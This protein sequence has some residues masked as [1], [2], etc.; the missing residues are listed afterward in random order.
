MCSDNQYTNI[1]LTNTVELAEWLESHPDAEFVSI[2]TS[3]SFWSERRDDGMFYPYDM[4]EDRHSLP[5]AIRDHKNLKILVFNGFGMC[6]LTDV[7]ILT[8]A[9]KNNNVLKALCITI[10]PLETT[11]EDK[12]RKI[13]I[14]ELMYNLYHSHAS[15]EKLTLRTYM[16]DE[17]V[18]MLNREFD[19]IL[20][21][22]KRSIRNRYLTE[23]RSHL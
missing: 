13:C 18:N 21:K 6:N 1:Y 16:E 9:I 2:K 19:N 14:R 8:R 4:V 20:T 12:I 7:N 17:K 3:W 22:C 11:N 15:F 23:G 10:K 5:V